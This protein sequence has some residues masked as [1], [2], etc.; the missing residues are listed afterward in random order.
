MRERQILPLVV[1]ALTGALVAVV[2]LW[3][4]DRVDSSQGD[5]TQNDALGLQSA[6]K[7]IEW[8]LVTTWPKG[9]PGLGAAPENFARRVNEASGGRLRIKVFGAGEIVP[10]FEVFDAV[11]RGVAEAGHG[12]SYYWKG[13]IPAAVFF[14]AVPFGM[15][16]Q[17]A[18]GWL[19]Y[20]GGLALWRELYAPFGVI[21]YAGGSTGVQMA[22]W[23]NTRLNSREDLAGLKMRIP[24]LAGE[25]FDAAGGSAVRIAGGEVYT[26]MQTGVIDAVEWVGPFN[27]RTLGL[28]EVGD[29]YYYPGWHE[30]G[31]MLET[32]VNAEALAA[33]P[34]DLQAIVRIAARATNTDM[35]DDF[36]A[37]NSESLQILLRDFDTEVL[38]LPDDVMDALYEQSQIAIQALVDADPMAKKIAA[39]YFAFSEKVRTYHEISER[40]YLNGRD[41]LLPPVKLTAE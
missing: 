39:S 2:A 1:V 21:P 16:A 35:L 34:E 31:A 12:A 32:I 15:T 4:L 36:T 40:A 41:R 5:L 19:H 33:L 25:V 24:G 7:V 37:N 14:T 38:P 17:E 29:Y 11:S 18:N 23:F 28:M 8:K 13:K 26:S 22:G 9:L 30:P 3:T 27:D 10:A 6:P 20:G